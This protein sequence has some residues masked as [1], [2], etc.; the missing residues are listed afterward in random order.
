MERPKVV[1]TCASRCPCFALNHAVFG[2]M[3]SHAPYCAL[4]SAESSIVWTLR[5]HTVR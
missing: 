3:D 1:H 5:Q 4:S 2:A